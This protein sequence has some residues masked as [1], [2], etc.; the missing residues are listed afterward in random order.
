MAKPGKC[1]HG[2]KVI[3]SDTTLILWNCNMCHSGPHWFI[4]ECSKCKLKACKPCSEKVR[5]ASQLCLPQGFEILTNHRHELNK[6]ACIL[7]SL[8]TASSWRSA[9]SAVTQPFFGIR[10]RTLAFDIVP[11]T[12]PHF[13]MI[14][15]RFS[16]ESGGMAMA[17]SW[18]RLAKKIALGRFGRRSIG[19][20]AMHV[21]EL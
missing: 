11:F 17:N 14:A 12:G 16:E 15:L 5:H 4:H 10:T 1:E 6:I 21:T 3:K 7:L 13:T 2:F 8:S 20:T 18:G 19:G 9:R